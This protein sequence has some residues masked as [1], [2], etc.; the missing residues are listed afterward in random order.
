M[1]LVPISS[2]PSSFKHRTGRAAISVISRSQHTDL[3]PDSDMKKPNHLQIA[4]RKRVEKHLNPDSS[5]VSQADA[6][7]RIEAGLKNLPVRDRIA[8]YMSHFLSEPK[9][10]PF[11]AQRSEDSQSLELFGTTRSGKSRLIASEVQSFLASSRKQSSFTFLNLQ[12]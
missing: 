8:F 3:L 9:C 4:E 7:S 2:Y 11:L 1:A 6:L 10:Q 5:Q 12:P